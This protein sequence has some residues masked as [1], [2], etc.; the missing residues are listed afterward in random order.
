MVSIY[1]LLC[2]TETYLLKSPLVPNSNFDTSSFVNNS[3]NKQIFN[4]IE[5]VCFAQTMK[6]QPHL[7]ATASFWDHTDPKPQL[8]LRALWPRNSLLSYVPTHWSHLLDPQQPLHRFPLWGTYPGYKSVK[9]SPNRLSYA[10]A[11]C[12]LYIFPWSAPKFL[13]PPILCTHKYIFL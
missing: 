5:S 8:S 6:P 4:H 7:L 3:P 10:T 1:W 13:K 9:A 2:L 12:W 11:P